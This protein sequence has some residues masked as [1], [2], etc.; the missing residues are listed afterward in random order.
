MNLVFDRTVLPIEAMLKELGLGDKK[1]RVIQSTY[2][3]SYDLS[4]VPI[5]PV[6]ITIVD[7]GHTFELVEAQEISSDKK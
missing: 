2:N 4:Y 1:Y 5:S 3:R 7:N 6:K